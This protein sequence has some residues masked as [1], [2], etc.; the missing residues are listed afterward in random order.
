[1][2]VR[3]KQRFQ[4]FDRAFLLLR[5]ALA[6]RDPLSFSDLEREGLA[7]RFEFTFELAWKTLKDYLEDGGLVIEPITPRNVIKEAFAAKL[8]TDGQ[9]WI[10]MM[11]DRNRLSHVYDETA[12]VEVLQTLVSRYL[13]VLEALHNYLLARTGSP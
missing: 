8:I 6:G 5:S 11:L 3:W 7:Q 4:N 10:D 1:M 2:D 9:A 12:L 13:P